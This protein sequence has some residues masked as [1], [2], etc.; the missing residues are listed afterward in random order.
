MK[1]LVTEI[2]TYE[3]GTVN[4]PSYAFDNKNSADAKY[5]QILSA[6]SLS[7][8]SVHAAIMYTDKGEYIKSE[9]FTHIPAPEKLPAE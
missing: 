8:L 4:T 5:H 7:S 2:Q 6:A 1:Y 3:N 9:Y